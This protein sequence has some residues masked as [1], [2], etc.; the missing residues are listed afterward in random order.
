[1]ND[2]AS[3]PAKGRG[4]GQNPTPRYAQQARVMLG[5]R[6]WWPSVVPNELHTKIP[7]LKPRAGSA[8]T[9]SE[10]LTAPIGFAVDDDPADDDTDVDYGVAVATASMV[11]EAWRSR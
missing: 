2:P 7:F 5:E 3:P 6:N 1:M 10:E 4:T 11:T 8:T 9:G